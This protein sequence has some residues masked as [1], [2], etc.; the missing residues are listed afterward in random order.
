MVPEEQDNTR[1]LATRF[2]IRT[3][4]QK[5]QPGTKAKGRENYL[6]PIGIELHHLD[7]ASSV[8]TERRRMRAEAPILS[9]VFFAFEAH[10]ISANHRRLVRETSAIPAHKTHTL[11]R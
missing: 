6:R 9:L 2:A 7:M 11:A 1:R 10:N 8:F 3:A 5:E 4:A